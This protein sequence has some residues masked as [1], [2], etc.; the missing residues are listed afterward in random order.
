MTNEVRKLL[1][2]NTDVKTKKG[3]KYG[4]LTGILYLAPHKESGVANLCP[5][6]TEGCKAACLF[7]AG[8]AM[9]FPKINQAR[10]AKTLLFKNDRKHFME[11]L[12]RDIETLERKAKR[13]GLK[14]CVRLN[15]TS[16]VDFSKFGIMD[17]YPHIIFYDYTKSIKR[18]LDYAA[19]K[20]PKNYH[21]TFSR[22]ESNGIQTHEAI[23]A[24]VN[25]AVVFDKTPETYKGKTVVNGDLSDLRFLDAPNSIIG[26]KAKGKARND[27]SGFVI[28]G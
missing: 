16:D 5:D 22:A 26:L 3:V 24:G 25:V 11:L 13:E 27:T 21:I 1:A 9:V 8:R 10:I 6:A 7:T 15:G 4:Y 28:H 17:K 12:Y 14:P 18:A 20:L 2:V 23:K 19:G